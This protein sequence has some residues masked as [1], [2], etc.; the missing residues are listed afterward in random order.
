LVT[1]VA[2]DSVPSAWPGRTAE[3]VRELAAAI[4]VVERAAA[5]LIRNPNESLLLE[6]MLVRLSAVTA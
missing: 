2:P 5:E 4:T 1:V 6:A 3:R